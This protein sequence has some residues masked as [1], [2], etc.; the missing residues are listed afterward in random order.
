MRPSL[1]LLLTCSI[2]ATFQVVAQSDV[3]VELALAEPVRD[4]A[5][6]ALAIERGELNGM[7]EHVR[8][9]V[10]DNGEPVAEDRSTPPSPI[11][12]YRIAAMA[13]V[14][15]QQ[16]GVLMVTSGYTRWGNAV[17]IVSFQTANGPVDRSYSLGT[18][19]KPPKPPKDP[20]RPLPRPGRLEVISVVEG[21]MELARTE[22]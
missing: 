8:K 17:L 3:R 2:T 13:E 22:Q 7:D 21:R 9:L 16:R 5:A 19:G 12:N 11:W 20:A 14:L 1:V 10:I 18:K 4:P 15:R 6:F